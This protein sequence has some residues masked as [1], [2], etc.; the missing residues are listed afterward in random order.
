MIIFY[1]GQDGVKREIPETVL[2]DANVMISYYTAVIIQEQDKKPNG[3][4][5]RLLRARRKARRL[6]NEDQ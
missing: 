4:L 6:S 3:R 5:Q 2:K 1:S